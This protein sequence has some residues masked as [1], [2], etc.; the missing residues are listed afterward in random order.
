MPPSE[1]VKTILCVED[2]EALREDI[3]EELEDAGYRV[4]QACDGA[5]GLNKI[6]KHRPDLVVSDITMP[7]M[8]GY[9]L[10]SALRAGHPELA[11]IPF[12]FLSALA[13]RNHILQG[14]E[15][16]ADDYITKPIDYDMLLS[17]VAARLR[18]TK[19]MAH[20]KQ[21][22][23]VKIYKALTSKLQA[24]APQAPA[25]DKTAEW[26]ATT[27][28]NVAI[29]GQSDNAMWDLHRMLHDAGHKVTV[30]TSGRAYL[31]KYHSVKP[32]LTCLWPETDD[33]TASGVAKMVEKGKTKHVLMY[34][35]MNSAKARNVKKEDLK[36]VI[37]DEINVQIPK[38]ELIEKLSSWL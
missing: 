33:V 16:G 22:E 37:K 23:Q 24:A 36:S 8:N 27:Q 34:T 1:D 4:F 15:V 2:E 21:E 10:I 35:K 19:R 5:D 9:E 18:Q 14:M 29:V 25:E 28:R 11:D 31:N 7:K 20:K 17:K 12:I 6:V 3:H 13:D 26:K 38:P 30:F 32:F